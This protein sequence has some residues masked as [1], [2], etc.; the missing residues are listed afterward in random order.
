MPTIRGFTWLQ[1]TIYLWQSL[2]LSTTEIQVL[3]GLTADEL[4]LAQAGC[5]QPTIAGLGTAAPPAG[6][7][8]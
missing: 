7:Q 1:V 2:G 6:L 5:W 4:H 3:W 8:D